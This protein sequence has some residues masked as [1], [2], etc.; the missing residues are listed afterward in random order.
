MMD[1]GRL[2]SLSL[3]GCIGLC[4]AENLGQKDS[5]LTVTSVGLVC[6]IVP[7]QVL[8]PDLSGINLEDTRL[9]CDMGQGHGL[10]PA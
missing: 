8:I 9:H 7:R 2:I 6:G 4:R 10:Y 1:D 5:S 3:G